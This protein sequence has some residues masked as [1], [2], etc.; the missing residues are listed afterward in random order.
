MTTRH[1][2]PGGQWAEFRDPAD[3]PE[4]L[5]RPITRLG[6][7][8]AQL[9]KADGAEISAEDI[10]LMYAMN[11]AVVLALATAWSFAEPITAEGLGNLPGPAYD[12]LLKLAAP[13]VEAL[14]PDFGPNPAPESPTVPLAA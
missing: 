7:K 2:L 14:L 13:S 8:A 6:P 9:V 5:R 3:V 4:R 12:A 11:D 10:D 1:D